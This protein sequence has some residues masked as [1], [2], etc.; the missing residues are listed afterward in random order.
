MK[1]EL[2]LKWLCHYGDAYIVVQ[3]TISATVQGA[4]RARVQAVRNNEQ[5]IFKN[6]SPFT[7]HTTEINS[8]Q[9]DM[10]MILML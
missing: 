2:K 8:T 1:F 3:G 9:V 10:Q 4:D 5:V 6:S 7:H